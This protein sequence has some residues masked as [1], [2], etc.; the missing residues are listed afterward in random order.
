M[1]FMYFVVIGK[2][3]FAQNILINIFLSYYKCV[4]YT[5]CFYKC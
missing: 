4:L 2:N 3:Y 1:D 5:C